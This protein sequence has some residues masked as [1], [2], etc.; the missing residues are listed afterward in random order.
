MVAQN[1][2]SVTAIK[3]LKCVSDN[4]DVKADYVTCVVMCNTYQNIT[5]P[6]MHCDT[7]KQCWYID[8]FVQCSLCSLTM[9]AFCFLVL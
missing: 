2:I 3:F 8:I 6:E 1:L 9:K 4:H 5:I 7:T